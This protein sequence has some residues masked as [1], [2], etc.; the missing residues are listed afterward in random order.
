MAKQLTMGQL[1]KEQWYSDAFGKPVSGTDHRGALRGFNWD[2]QNETR[3]RKIRVLS[4]EEIAEEL[5]ARE[6]ADAE[7]IARRKPFIDQYLR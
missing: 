6:R 5:A 3:A 1:V 7:G 2:L 4:D